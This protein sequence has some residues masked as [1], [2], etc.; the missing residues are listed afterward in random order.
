MTGPPPPFRPTPRSAEPTDPP[1]SA[2]IRWIVRLGA[3]LV[4]TLAMTWRIRVIGDAG[5]RDERAE[6][7]AVII[8]LWHGQM[9]PLLYQHRGEQVA[10]LISEHRDGEIIARIA[11]ALGHRTVRGSTT[12]GAGRALL[13]MVRQV[14]AG[15]DIAVTP[16]GPR[17]PA[18]SFA[19]GALIVAQRT[20]AA[21]IPATVVARSA[22][23]LGS[24]D[25]FMIPRPFARIVISYGPAAHVSA[26]DARAASSE[27]PRFQQLMEDAERAAARA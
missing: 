19:P 25:S 15:Q 13:S 6:G 7:R 22:W 8:T 2:K 26:G 11:M 24:W 18:K 3:L 14:E 23:R 27:A 16:D 17:G 4:R 20:G 1:P 10:V 9:L 12:R 5:L 21:I